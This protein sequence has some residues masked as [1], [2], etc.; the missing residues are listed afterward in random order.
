MDQ[1]PD[2][3]RSRHHAAQR[4]GSRPTSSS[5]CQITPSI[6]TTF[7]TTQEKNIDDIERNSRQSINTLKDMK[8]KAKSD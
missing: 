1:P 8:K 5:T 4:Q 2:I 6:N 7:N 3:I